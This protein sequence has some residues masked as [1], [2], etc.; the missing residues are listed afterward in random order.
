MVNFLIIIPVLKDLKNS[1]EKKECFDYYKEV[2]V[3]RRP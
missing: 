1:L 3:N 2:K